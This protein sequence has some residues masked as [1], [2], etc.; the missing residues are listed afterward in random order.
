[1]FRTSAFLLG[2]LVC[3]LSLG[4]DFSLSFLVSPD[5]LEQELGYASLSD[6]LEVQMTLHSTYGVH[7]PLQL[8]VLDKL[9]SYYRLQGRL[10]KADEIERLRHLILKKN[11]PPN[12]YDMLLATFRLGSWQNFRGKHTDA[13]FTFEDG[14]ELLKDVSPRLEPARLRR[15][16]YAF[17]MAADLASRQMF[18]K[19]D[20]ASNQARRTSNHW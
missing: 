4:D 10:D 19:R 3:D 8:P 1:M 15:A 16:K 20:L 18:A 5:Q 17:N 11:S 2:L 7:T 12:S 6:L 9:G 14:L 13:L